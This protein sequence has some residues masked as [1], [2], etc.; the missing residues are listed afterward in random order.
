MERGFKSRCEQMSK[1]I[2]VELGLEVTAPLCPDKLASYLNILIWDV[3]TI[4]LTDEDLNQ[5][6]IRDPDSWSAITVSAYGREAIIVNPRH[7]GGRYSSDI[8]HELAHLLLGHQPSTVFFAG[9][10]SLALRGYDR[11]A[12]EEADW[13]AGALLLPRDVLVLLERQSIPPQNACE[14]YGVSKRMLDYRARI[15]GVTRQF[16]SRKASVR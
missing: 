13:L 6:V 16:S 9:E 1:S 5:L 14:S 11:A 8:M 3:G 15:T 4:G 7:R 12:E 2:R 10:E